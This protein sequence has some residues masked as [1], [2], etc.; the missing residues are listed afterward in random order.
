M[1]N[2]AVLLTRWS[3]RNLPESR[4]TNSRVLVDEREIER[5]DA[6]QMLT[7]YGIRNPHEG[8]QTNSRVSIGHV[9]IEGADSQQRGIAH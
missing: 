5:T 1:L 4:Q 7:R 2:S 8:R 6:Q 3:I 9:E